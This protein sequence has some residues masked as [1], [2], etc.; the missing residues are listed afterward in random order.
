MGKRLLCTALC[1]A[2]QPGGGCGPA[3]RWVLPVLRQRRTMPCLP[4][5]AAPICVAAELW[6]GVAVVQQVASC[7]ACCARFPSLPAVLPPRWRELQ[8]EDWAQEDGSP[9]SP[10]S[11]SG[12][13]GGQEDGAAGSEAASSEQTPEWA[14]GMDTDTQQ[15]QEDSSGRFDGTHMASLLFYGVRG[16]Q[17]REGDAPSYFNALEV[18]GPGC[19]L[20]VSCCIR[21]V[22]SC[23]ICTATTGQHSGR[24]GCCWAACLVSSG[25]SVAPY[26]LPVC[27]AAG[28]HRGG[29][30]CWAAQCGGGCA[31]R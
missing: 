26:A 17:Q 10:G 5:G 1:T 30:G 13:E 28:E 25:A 7:T 29:A 21:R 19:F 4:H 20:Q 6:W 9:S 15:Q 31:G 16:Q 18:S 27:L 2:G 3:V 11:R 22:S 14:D 24:A 12:S 8:A 23:V